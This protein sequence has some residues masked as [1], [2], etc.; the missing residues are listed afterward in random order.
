M[1]FETRTNL[2]CKAVSREHDAWFVVQV[3]KYPR[4]SME[5]TANTMPR[6]SLGYAVV[7][8]PADVAMND[9]SNA[10]EWFPRATVLN[11]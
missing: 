1:V 8:G 3:V 6:E 4:R 2:Y 5:N 11:C 10:F 9:L 7:A